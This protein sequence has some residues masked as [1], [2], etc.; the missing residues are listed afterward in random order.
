MRRIVSTLICGLFLLTLAACSKTEQASNNAATATPSTGASS[1]NTEKV[2]PPNIVIAGAPP[3]QIA[4]GSSADAVVLVSIA[5]GYHINAN[6]ASKYQIAT[7][8]EIEPAEGLRAS[9]EPQYPPSLTKKFSFSEEPIAVYEGQATIKI[10]L[11]AAGDARKGEHSLRAK[12]RVQP[13]DEQACYP[14]RN[15]EATLPVTVK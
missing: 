7:T 15:I 2:P 11:S 6:P 4:Q 10:Q 12:V 8:L 9:S 1:A 14:P 3:V 13:C 5:N